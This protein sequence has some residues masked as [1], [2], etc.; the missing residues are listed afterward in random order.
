MATKTNRRGELRY[1]GQVKWKGKQITRWFGTT[2]Q[3]HRKA[4]VWEEETRERVRKEAETT[5]TDSLSFLQWGNEYL[6]YVKRRY[7]KKTYKEK[8][9][10]FKQFLLFA[11]EQ[12]LELEEMSTPFALKYLQAQFDARSG[13][14]ANKDRKNLAAAWEWGRKYL[15]SF[16][17]ERVNPFAAVEKFPEERKPRYV[18]PL[19]DFDKVIAEAEGQDQVMLL[20]C[21]HLA[22][23][24]GELFKLTWQDVDF[25]NSQVCLS[26]RKTRNGS[27]KRVW[28]P[29]STEL[30]KELL[31][32][33]ENRPYKK[34][35]YVFINTHESHSPTHRPGEPFVDRKRFM[36]SLCK[37]AEVEPFGFHAIRH[38]SASY[39]YRIGKPV[40]LIQKILRHEAPS[41]TER[42]LKSLG[43]DTEE[44]KGAI[45]E[46]SRR[47]PAE[48]IPL[49]E[50]NPRSDRSGGSK[51][52]QRGYPVG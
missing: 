1:R 40:S 13:Y 20:A 5:L 38:L 51:D 12:D 49:K 8:Q 7:V 46:F 21:L 23:R 26:T 25:I 16:P 28:L 47:E 42:Y 30:R 6:G 45:E 34:A 39:L 32:W 11:K 9:A 14:A 15:E 41:T 35:K 52:I 27:V 17:R 37:R 33:W 18:P 50:K 10:V 24:R 43:F 36:G 2:K 3:E 4:V 29:M 31:W 48:V 22:A 19:E 44:L